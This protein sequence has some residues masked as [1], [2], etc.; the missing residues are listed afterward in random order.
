MKTKLALLILLCS[1]FVFSQNIVECN[2]KKSYWIIQNNK[3]SYAIEL[4]GKV[5]K[6][7]NVNL[8]ALNNLP[9]QSLLV[10]KSKF[11]NAENKDDHF[12]ILKAYVEGEHEYLNT[13][14]KTELE[15]KMF[16]IEI[17]G[18][19]TSIFWYFKLPEG[20]NAEVTSQLFASMIMDDK[21]FGLST[22]QFKSQDFQKLQYQL[23]D[24]L[25]SVKKIDSD[26][27]LCN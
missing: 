15:L 23:L 12:E 3:D 17:K 9:L 26:K 6:T 4:L 13:Q 27:N 11:V 1:S 21:I 7:D 10:D 18:S 14:F 5:K 20:Q 2:A 8:I 19:M 25:Y 22:S 16:K 24:T